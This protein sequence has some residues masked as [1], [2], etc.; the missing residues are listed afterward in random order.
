MRGLPGHDAFRRS[1]GSLHMHYPLLVLLGPEPVTYDILSTWLHQPAEKVRRMAK[2]LVEAG[3]A[4]ALP[5]GVAA[6]SLDRRAALAEVARTAGTL[7]MR[8]NAIRLYETKCRDWRLRQQEWCETRQQPG[9]DVWRSSMERDAREAL[10]APQNEVLRLTWAA[11]G[12]SFEDL[13]ACVIEDQLVQASRE[14][15]PAHLVPNRPR[16]LPSHALDES[17]VL[18]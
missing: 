11:T 16:G 10:G 5:T 15:V 14:W 8:A 18:V 12:K 1:T 6:S 7:G 3:L 17:A 9:S 2:R 4:V 13:V